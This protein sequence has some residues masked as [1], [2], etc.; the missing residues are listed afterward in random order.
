MGRGCQRDQSNTRKQRSH[1]NLDFH[2]KR[3]YAGKAVTICCRESAA[4][5]IGGTHPCAISAPAAAMLVG[6]ADTFIDL[7]N[8]LFDQLRGRFLVAALVRG[9]LTQR[10]KRIL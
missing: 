3:Y 6:E 9:R 2:S 10:L 4:G 7:H 1:E 5:V 8:R